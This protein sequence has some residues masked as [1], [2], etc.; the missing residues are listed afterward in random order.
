M[1]LAK[2]VR[3]LKM[4]KV[5]EGVSMKYAGGGDLRESD[6]VARAEKGAS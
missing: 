3:K 4:Y 2:P 5:G 1:A 6:F